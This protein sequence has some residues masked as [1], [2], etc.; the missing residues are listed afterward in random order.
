MNDH[1]H[2]SLCVVPVLRRSQS[3][4]RNG[5]AV[6]RHSTA[7]HPA[8]SALTGSRL[9]PSSDHC[10]EALRSVSEGSATSALIA[11]RL[12][13]LYAHLVGAPPFPWRSLCPSSGGSAPI[14]RALVARPRP[15][16]PLRAH[17]QQRSR[18]VN[19][20]KP[21]DGGVAELHSLRR[22]GQEPA[23]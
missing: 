10:M 1:V 23:P 17:K 2:V 22:C 5:V 4:P 9:R 11:L 6:L 18:R 12:R 8:P 21:Q 20:E 3:F 16:P 13:P 15:R 19:R 14:Q 7:H